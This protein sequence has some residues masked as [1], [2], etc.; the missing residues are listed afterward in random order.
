MDRDKASLS[1]STPQESPG[2]LP[3]RTLLL[4]LVDCRKTPGQSGT[5][6]LEGEEEH[7]DV[8][9][10]SKNHGDIPNRCSLSGRGLSS[11]E[12]Q[13]HD[14]DKIWSLSISEHLK[15]HQHRGAG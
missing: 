7:G 12:P 4:V 11:G 9:S 13:H 10:L 1:P 14:A 5:K 8:I 15:K 3:L 2:Q 6:R